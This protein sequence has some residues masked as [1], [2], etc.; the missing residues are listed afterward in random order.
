MDRALHLVDVMRPLMNGMMSG[1]MIRILRILLRILLRMI[2]RSIRRI[3]S[4][5]L[6]GRILTD[7]RDGLSWTFTQPSRGRFGAADECRHGGA[8]LACA[9]ARGGGG[10]GGGRGGGGGGGSGGHGGRGGGGGVSKTQCTLEQEKLRAVGK[11]PLRGGR[12][13]RGGG[14]WR[15]SLMKRRQWY[16]CSCASTCHLCIR[17]CTV[18]CTVLYGSTQQRHCLCWSIASG[19]EHGEERTAECAHGARRHPYCR[20][21]SR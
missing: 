10:S 12:S 4:R 13:A 3:L 18:R 11:R 7:S 1:M 14:L 20:T 8:A 15:G 9:L 16:H 2:R 17:R 19:G 21:E 6:I 5:R